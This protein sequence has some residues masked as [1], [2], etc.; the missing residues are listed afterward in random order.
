MSEILVEIYRNRSEIEADIILKETGEVFQRIPVEWKKR[1]NK[2]DYL[3]V[4]KM[5]AYNTCPA[6]F[7]RQYMSDQNP[8]EDGGN[9]FT[10]F[11]S[12]LHEVTEMAVKHYN[13]TGIV[14]NPLTLYDNAWKN[15]GLNNFESYIEGK[16]LIKSYFDNNP[17]QN[18]TDST[19]AVEYEWRGE[20]GGVTFGLMFDYVGQVG[21]TTGKIKDYK[22]N[23]MPFTPDQLQHSLQL[24]IYEIVARKIWPEFKTWITGYDL[25]RYGWQQCPQRTQDDLDDAEQFVANTAY[26][27]EHDITWEERLNNYCGYRECRFTCEKYR[28]FIDNPG[29]FVEP[30]KTDNMTLEQIEKERVLM[31]AYEKTIKNRKDELNK[32]MCTAVQE[33]LKAGK[34]LVI[35]DNILELYSN[36]TKSYR[37]YDTRNTLLVHN[38]LNIL[39]DCMNI[40]KAK[41]DKKIAADPMLKLQLESCI[42]TNYASP[43]ITKKKYKGKK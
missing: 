14:V 35:D 26:Q 32:I 18:M 6:C 3:S 36:A 39:D 30:I 37:Y 4:S 17:V 27:I 38:K 13:E 11:G 42:D 31:T 16:E 12:I 5:E 33:S 40:S 25:F 28:K 15:S 24:R 29:K 10:K 8:G 34:Q 22:S 9:F 2:L 41:L 1:E 7:Y 23:R 20:L 21:P 43:Y 19:L